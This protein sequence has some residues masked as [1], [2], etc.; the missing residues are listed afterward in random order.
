MARLALIPWVLLAFPTFGQIASAPNE[1]IVPPGIPPDERIDLTGDDIPDVVITGITEH[2]L[3]ENHERAGW[4]RRWVLPL[5]GTALLFRTTRNSTGYYKLADGGKLSPVELEAG[6]R[7]KQLRWSTPADSIKLEV[8]EHSFGLGVPPGWYGSD[9]FQEGTLVLRSTM[10][11]RA[12]IAAFTIWCSFPAGRIGITAKG[13]VPVAAH[14]GESEPPK[15]RV[16]SPDEHPKVRMYNGSGEM[17]PQIVIPP[18]I[19]PEERIDLSQDDIPDVVLSGYVAHN[20]NPKNSGWYRRGLSPL[21]GTRL[22]MEKQADG[23]YGWFQLKMG[24]ALTPEHL[25]MNLQS[26]ALRWADPERELVMVLEL[27]QRFGFG[28]DYGEDM[29]WY[30]PEPF[31]TEMLVFRTAQYGRP[32]IGS[33]ELGNAT[34]GGEMWINPQGLVNEGEVLKV[35]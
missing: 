9:N 27:E 33:F 13:S 4:Y 32:M 3:G 23:T 12:A 18:G 21:P 34:P 7:N 31:I 8:L 29:G 15:P 22:L 11:E 26:G 1:P 24:E 16:P 19:P 2:V 14:F 5:P 30:R 28:P 10:G 20:D 25:A 6:F 35:D 17:E